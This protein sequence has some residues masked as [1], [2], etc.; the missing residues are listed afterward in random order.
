MDVES[1]GHGTQDMGHTRHMGPK[2]MGHK[3]HRTWDTKIYGTKG[4]GSQGTQDMGHNE[5]Y[6]TK[7]HGTQ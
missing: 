4:H 5:T 6:G 2:D 7:G 3:A 1:A